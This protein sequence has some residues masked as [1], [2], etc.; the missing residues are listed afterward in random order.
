MKVVTE[1]SGYVQNGFQQ[2]SMWLIELCPFCPSWLIQSSSRDNLV[3]GL[4]V[5]YCMSLTM[6]R[7]R[8]SLKRQILSKLSRMTSV[9]GS[10]PSEWGKIA[11]LRLGPDTLIDKIIAASPLC[12]KQY[13]SYYRTFV[14]FESTELLLLDWPPDHG[15]VL[16][17]C[18][19]PSPK[20]VCDMAQLEN[21]HRN[22]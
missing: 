11:L 19:F 18:M 8:G 20:Q 3:I 10:V 14:A 4:V 13:V 1:F 6:K 7:S 12:H 15:M 16:H 17:G 21:W 22:I 2:K 5:L 9:R